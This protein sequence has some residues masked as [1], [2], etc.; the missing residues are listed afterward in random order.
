MCDNADVTYFSS[1]VPTLFLQVKRPFSYIL[2]L[3]RLII[4]L[5]VF[6]KNFIQAFRVYF[7]NIY[8]FKII[9]IFRG[10]ICYMSSL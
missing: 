6:L 7:V 2:S 10:N 1:R 4:F 3:V 9:L 8:Y 5:Q